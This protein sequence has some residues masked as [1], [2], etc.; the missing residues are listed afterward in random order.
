[1]ANI[2]VITQINDL[3]DADTTAL[4]KTALG[5]LGAATTGNASIIAADLAPNAV[6]TAKIADA[7]V[8]LAKITGLGTAAT[9]DT[10]T[11]GGANKVPLLD[12]NGTLRLGPVNPTDNQPTQSLLIPAFQRTLYESKLG[13]T[14]AQ[15]YLIANHS[16]ALGNDIGFGAGVFPE[17]FNGSP[18]HC[19]YWDEGF[20]MGNAEN[21]R[22]YGRYLYFRALGNASSPDPVRQ[23]VPTFWNGQ[24]WNGGS[25]V[26]SN[27]GLQ[28]VPGTTSTSGEF[29]FAIT[30]TFSAGGTVNAL[31]NGVLTSVAGAVLPFS[32]TQ[33]G[34]KVGVGKVLTFG[35]GTTMDTAPQPYQARTGNATLVGGTVTVADDTVTAYTNIM[36]TRRYAGGTIGDLTYSVSNGTSFTITS[37]SA[38]DTS[39]VTYHLVESLV[40][41]TA[42]TISGTNAVSD[43]LTVVSGGGGGGYQWYSNGFAVS[44]FT[45]STYTIRHQ[46]IGLDITCTEGG[47]ASNAITAWHPDDESGYFAD[48]R[49][50][51]GV[52]TTG[53]GAATHGQVI[54][55]WQDVSGNARHV[56]QATSNYRPTF[57]STTYAGYPH[58][59]GDGVDDYL[60][61]SVTLT[62]PQTAFIVAEVVSIGN[63]DRIFAT[64][65]SGSRML[66]QPDLG[67]T[68]LIKNGAAITPSSS[69]AV[70][71]RAIVTARTTSTQNHIRLNN[72]TEYSATETTGNGAELVIGG[73]SATNASDCR[74]FAVLFYQAELDTYAQAR[75]RVYLKAKW[76]TP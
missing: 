69:W 14:A 68:G 65:G 47:V 38:T 57:D 9:A 72:G 33:A 30:P 49:A 24:N 4:A 71:T 45:G 26:S 64:A 53:G 44:G 62:R 25:T 20:Q 36:L 19:F 32:V 50:D 27:M 28:W 51:T 22:S 23:S 75:V 74:I 59:R 37:A 21:N 58:M 48:F 35:D 17:L 15:T 3:L 2:E 43:V 52:L 40:T 46:D 55:T 16:A 56:T 5:V 54:E 6:T 34:P 41:A 61:R 63:N 29:V 8:T 70:N 18:R 73:S 1:M 39:R 66:V 10:S 76:G 12:S 67:G 60:A 11:T 7:N 13:T 31:T 42:P